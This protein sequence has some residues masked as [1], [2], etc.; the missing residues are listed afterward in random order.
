M[1][2]PLFRSATSTSKCYRV[3]D[4][5]NNFISIQEG[6]VF[7]GPEGQEIGFVYLPKR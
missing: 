3:Y 1:L 2:D 6:E 7:G 4:L 5:F